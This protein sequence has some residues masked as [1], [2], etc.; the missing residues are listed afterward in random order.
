MKAPPTAQPA[1]T[2]QDPSALVSDQKQRAPGIDP[3]CRHADATD[4][5]LGAETPHNFVR[6]FLG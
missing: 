4:A 3:D 2:R 6:P 1:P 5:Q